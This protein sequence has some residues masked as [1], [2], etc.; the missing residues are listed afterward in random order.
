[1]TFSDSGENVTTLEHW[2][3]MRLCDAILDVQVEPEQNASDPA[4]LITDVKGPK[5]AW[6]GLGDRWRRQWE[7]L[8]KS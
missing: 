2:N 7:A 8:V 1:M 6:H 3:E 5:E 4:L